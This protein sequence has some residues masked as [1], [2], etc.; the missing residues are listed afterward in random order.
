ML[1][2]VVTSLTGAAI[3]AA[4]HPILKRPVGERI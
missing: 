3:I 4:R 1:V 2:V